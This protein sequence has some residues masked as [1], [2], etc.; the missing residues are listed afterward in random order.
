MQEELKRCAESI[1]ICCDLHRNSKDYSDTDL[2]YAMTDIADTLERLAGLPTA[3]P[4]DFLPTQDTRVSDLSALS[5][6]SALIHANTSDLQ[7][8][9]Y[10]LCQVAVAMRE[11]AA[12]ESVHPSVRHLADTIAL[13]LTAQ[14]P[15]VDRG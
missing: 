2:F 7:V 13:N 5:A 4:G 3:E 9:E 8:T 10:R 6:L 14:A 11:I 1:R 12:K 15:E